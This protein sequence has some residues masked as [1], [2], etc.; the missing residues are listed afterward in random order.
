MR[1]RKV[2][3]STH[4]ESLPVY[5]AKQNAR[6]LLKQKQHEGK[7]DQPIGQNARRKAMEDLKKIRK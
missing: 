1:K 7:N 2:R 5:M 3:I 4:K 6:V